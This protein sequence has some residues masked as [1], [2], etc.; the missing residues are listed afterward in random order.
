[1]PPSYPASGSTGAT[2]SNMVIIG[3]PIVTSIPYTVAKPTEKPI[4][5]PQ[6][7]APLLPIQE[8]QPTQEAAMETV[9]G[10]T[11]TVNELDDLLSTSPPFAQGAVEAETIDPKLIGSPA[12]SDLDSDIL[13][14]NLAQGNLIQ[15]G[16]VG[17]TSETKPT[18]PLIDGMLLTVTIIT[19]IGLVYMI[20]VA[21]DYRQRWMQS[22]MMQNDRYLGS[23]GAFDIDMEDTYSGSFSFSEGFGL[24]RRS[25]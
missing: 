2:M 1:M 5:V 25:I 17:Q 4:L 9:R 7:L 14:A 10:Q 22:L 8:I 3:E 24:T 18:D 21:Y 20:F 6:Q 13:A 11:M 16:T 23:G 12:L 15:A 19:T